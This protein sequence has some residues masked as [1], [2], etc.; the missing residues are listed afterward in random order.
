MSPDASLV[1][2]GTGEALDPELPNTS[3]LVRGP[4]TLLLDCGYAVPHALWTITR[5][6]D[7]LDAVWISHGHADHCFGLPALLLWMRLQGRTRPLSVFGGPGS[8]ARLEQILELGY[9][10]SYA[11]HKC[12]P[13]EFVELHVGELAR[14]GALELRIAPTLHSLANWALRID[15]R[16]ESGGIGLRS[17]VYSGDGAPTEASRT[18]C[19]GASLL[20]HECFH[21]EPPA[22]ARKHGDLRGLL[23]LADAAGV[24]TL[25][26]LHFSADERE[27][28]ADAALAGARDT[29]EVVVP[30]PGDVI[31]LSRLRSDS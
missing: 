6:A 18:L 26:V 20:V 4:R 7:E 14:F 29:L 15:F 30:R 17:L 5:D 2:V 27:A 25:A 12:Y 19:M 22:G 13:I 21:V 8:R 11:P 9:P 31:S 1:F 3:L 23:E 28:I 16:H 24:D 10:G